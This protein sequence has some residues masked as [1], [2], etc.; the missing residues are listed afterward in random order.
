MAKDKFHDLVRD[1]LIKDGWEITHDPLAVEFN[2]LRQVFIDLGAEKII[3]AQ[4]GTRKIAVEIKSFIGVSLLKDLYVALGQF[5]TY[6]TL[7]GEQ[8]PDRK[9]YLAVPKGAYEGFLVLPSVQRILKDTQTP[10][11]IY[12]VEKE[13][14]ATWLE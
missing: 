6:R 7:L 12:D 11:I 8:E 10:L 14:V 4:K 13:V 1:A 3:T 2:S 9:L 5:V